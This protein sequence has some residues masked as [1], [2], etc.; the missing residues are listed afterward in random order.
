MPEHKAVWALGASS[1]VSLS[2]ISAATVLGDGH[3]VFALGQAAFRPYTG[4]ER[5]MLRAA[6]G[7]WSGPDVEAAA[8][9]V[10]TAHGELLAGFSGCELV[11][12]DG[13]VLAHDPAGA[14]RLQLGNGALLAELLGR[15]VVWDFH[16]GDME[17]GGQ[18]APLAPFFLHALARHGDIG[19]PVVF[20]DTGATLAMTR[21]DPG[22]QTPEEP[23]AVFAFEAGP[24]PE[25]VAPFLPE[26]Q[27]VGDV[28]L[29]GG[30]VCHDTL[31][32]YLGGAWFSRLPP[33]SVPTGQVRALADEL[34]ALAPADR[35]ATMRAITARTVQRGLELFDRRPDSVILYGPHRDDATLR[36]ALAR[37]CRCDVLATEQLGLDGEHMRARAIAHLALRV[38]RG[39]TTSC[40]A[41]TGVAAAVGGGRLSRPSG[42][43]P[44]AGPLA[45]GL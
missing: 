6:L 2:G 43:F 14:R 45:G 41:T 29:D 34:C 5:D 37:D 27:G 22:R 8:E 10:E 35:R 24:G 3:D 32:R 18:G 31:E 17:L 38:A 23:G 40:P 15:P 4:A 7:Q 13:H 28:P 30:R 25:A 36:D 39:L 9:V 12:F 16:S 11:G 44:A 26:A 33:K 20:V 1:D 21:V 42:Q 19:R